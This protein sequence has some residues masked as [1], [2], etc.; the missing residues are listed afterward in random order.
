MAIQILS[1]TVP[2]GGWVIPKQLVQHGDIIGDQ[3]LLV[4]KKAWRTS[5]TICGRLIKLWSSMVMALETMTRDHPKSTCVLPEKLT[6]I[7]RCSVD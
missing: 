3:R 7:R 1:R 6:P 2:N 4:T 5:L